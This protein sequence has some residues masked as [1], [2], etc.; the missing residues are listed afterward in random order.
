MK[1]LFGQCL[2]SLTILLLLSAGASA[3]L[4]PIPE[5]RGATGLALALR[6]LGAGATFMHITAHPDDEDNGLLVMMSRGR[7][8][9][10]ALLTVTRG[11][12][13]QN[14]I[15]TELEEALGVLRSAELMAIHRIDG[16]EQYFTRAYE[17]GYSF[18]VEETFEKWGKEEILADV[19]RIIRT[20]R[21]DVI[22]SLPLA[23][24]GGGQH[25]QASGRLAKEAFRAAA[26]PNRFPEQIQAGLR[27]WQ[28]PKLYSRH[29]ILRREDRDKPDPPFTVP[30][31]TGQY[32]P[33]L[34]LSYYQLGLQARANH[35]CQ[36]IGQLRGLPGEHLS[37]WVPQDAVVPVAEGET[38]LFNGVPMGLDRLKL[39]L[40][41]ETSETSI[42]LREGLN[43]LQL[44]IESANDAYDAKAPWKTLE[45]LREGLKTVRRLRGILASG[46]VSETAAYEL[47]HRLSYKEKSFAE[48]IA[49]A[50]G[51]ALDAIADRREVVPG[52]EF[53]VKV[54]VTNRSPVPVDVVSVDLQIP[55]GWKQEAGSETSGRLGDNARLE[56]PFEVAVGSDAE[57]DRPYWVRNRAVDRYDLV[58]PEH[59]GLPFA[60]PA[61]SA[62]VTFRSGSV[63]L[64]IEK[65]VQH[66]Y[67]GTWVGTEKQDRVVV[68]PKISLALSPKVM[69]VPVG[70]RGSGNR[71]RTASVAVLYK[72]TEEATGSLRLAAPTGWNVS[73]VSAP[74][75]FQREDEATTLK[76][77]LTP[78]DSVQPGKYEVEALVTLDGKEY[79][80]GFQ[81]IAYHHIQT[82]YLFRP[83]R[84][85][86][87]VLNVQVAP[88]RVG[89]IMGVG[90]EVAEAARQ[91]GADVVMLDENDLA[92]GNLSQFDLIITGIRSYFNRTDLRA[93]NQRLLE[94]VE[95]GGIMIVLY[96][97]QEWDDAQWGPYPAKYSRSRIT[98][99]EAP[100]RILE[101]T[102]PLFNYPNRITENDW[103]GWVQER[104][105][106]FLGERDERY[107]DLLASEDP[108][109][110]NAGEK[111]GMLVEAQYGKGRWIYVGLTLFRQLPAG[112]PD[113]YKFFANLLS[114]PKAPR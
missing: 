48:A 24:E 52:S 112:V 43:D 22:V 79:R 96:N 107:R 17:F 8:L 82:R 40:N 29:W 59:F 65:P 57:P 66:R 12:G 89:Y 56:V 58:R 72:G 94:Y 95:N 61:A 84:A 36:R 15:G 105:T 106:Y 1:R 114:L 45:P 97:R 109:E 91:L 75:R 50:H 35:L 46:D 33:I 71:A 23:G 73:P 88:V 74:V 81:R 6:K 51:L 30:M 37:K 104:G 39:F 27:P 21:P 62:R 60:P 28:P 93:Y 11:D 9:R 67:P 85:T 32:D 4:E 26:D 14:Q 77:E 38:D 10:T 103:K 2:M 19:V 92:E 53:E 99:E 108:R 100:V 54:Q 70:L 87:Q 86:I 31:N 16:V 5:D 3:Q 18:S 20:V 78:P 63:D 113:A 83:A 44:Q 102:H 69:V 68:L 55:G 110:Y 49:L 90:D 80:E 101:P 64:W 47:E 13:G 76:F 41:N 7:G 25:H 111:R 34:G 98:V 42:S